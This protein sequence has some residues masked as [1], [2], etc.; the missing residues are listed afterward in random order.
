MLS[1]K[2]M[3]EVITLGLLLYR[4]V[5]CTFINTHCIWM[6]KNLEIMGIMGDTSRRGGLSN[7]K[8][9]FSEFFGLELQDIANF[10]TLKTLR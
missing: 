3:G 8:Y 6:V 10:K 9:M 7:L 4:L 5:Q 2:V 1:M